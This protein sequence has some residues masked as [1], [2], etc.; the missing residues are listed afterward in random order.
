MYS[1]NIIYS[2]VIS[3]VQVL[4]I[5]AVGAV[6]P[7]VGENWLITDIGCSVWVGAP[8][9]SLPSILVS[10]TDGIVA[11]PIAQDGADNKGWL[12]DMKYYLSRT[13]WMTPLTQAQFVGFQAS[14][15]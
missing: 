14:S 2:S 10:L 9:A 5:G 15:G 11:P 7:P 12:D 4:G 13:N 3:N 8:P 1:P 6:R